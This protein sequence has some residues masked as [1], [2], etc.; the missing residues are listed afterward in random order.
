M[1]RM[2]QLANYTIIRNW[3]GQSTSDDLYDLCDQ[4]G[5]LLWDEFFEPHPADGPIPENI[6][7]YLANVR[8]K[9][10]RYRNH[11]SIA[12]WCA[13]NEGDPPPAIGEGIQKLIR[14]FDPIRLYQPS[15]TSG[16]GVNSGGPT[17]GAR[18]ASFTRSVKLLRPR[19]GSMS[20]PTL[21][22]VQAMMP[23]KDW[24]V[25]NDDWAEHDFCAG[26]QEGD[27]YPEIISSRYGYPA[28][29]PDFVRKAQLANYEAFRAM[30]EGR[31]AKLF[32]RRRA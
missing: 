14:E 6:D 26:A 5:L 19:F 24:E 21:E 9:I 13:R 18:R 2:H 16:R 23:E 22:A 25:V 29:L 20:V 31:F 11:P 1:I 15:S 7:L 28:N 4:Y 3:V 10:L 17:T 12:L 8:E 27:R 32:R 30:Y